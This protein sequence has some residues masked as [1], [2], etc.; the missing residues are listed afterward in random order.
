M[1]S[2]Q[3]LDS[4]NGCT[5][6]RRTIVPNFIPIRSEKLKPW[7]FEDFAPTIRTTTRRRRTTTTTSAAI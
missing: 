2:Y 3:K 5:F 6:T 1:T 4:T 7:V